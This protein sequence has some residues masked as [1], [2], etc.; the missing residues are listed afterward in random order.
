MG[1]TVETQNR[2]SK[3]SLVEVTQDA[4]LGALEDCHVRTWLVD[5]APLA[6]LRGNPNGHS[7]TLHAVAMSCSKVVVSQETQ[8][9]C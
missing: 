5:L 8:E 7:T 2:I 3:P 9:R 4:A 6:C 1:E